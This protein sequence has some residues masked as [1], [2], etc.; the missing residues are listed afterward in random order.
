MALTLRGNG[1]V[2]SD[3]YGIDSDGSITA[4]GITSTGNV[5]INRSTPQSKFEVWTG[6]GELSH[7]G[8]NNANATNNYTGISLGYAE[9]GANS[10]YRKVGI[11]AV[12]RADGAA[13]QDLAFLVDNNADGNSVDLNDT[14]MRISHEGYV[15]TP[16]QPSF[17]AK[18]NSTFNYTGGTGY[19]TITNFGNAILNRSNSYNTSNST[20][21]APVTGHYH[22]NFQ[23]LL[24]NV[25][26]GD[27]SIHISFVQNAAQQIYGNI[28]S[29]GSAANSVVGYGQYLPVVG[30]GDMYMSANDTLQIKL[31]STGSMGVYSGSD[32]GRFSGHLI[33]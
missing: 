9:A 15:T 22:F 3:N 2:S 11:V 8:S 28:R 30:V 19:Q 4:T 29:P 16:S 32:W 14:K 21:T 25:D 23:L 33:G 1:Q 6:N 20:F 27:D 26:T 10:N 12:G 13:R 24:M 17:I 5:G 18:T 7:F 31:S